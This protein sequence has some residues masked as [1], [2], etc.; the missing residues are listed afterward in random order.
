MV[1]DYFTQPQAYNP[2]K[3]F[4][5]EKWKAVQNMLIMDCEIIFHLLAKDEGLAVFFVFLIRYFPSPFSPFI[6][7]KNI[8]NLERIFL[9]ILENKGKMF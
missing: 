6:S 1:V 5:F 3:A 9:M 2:A 8:A 4:L 7:F